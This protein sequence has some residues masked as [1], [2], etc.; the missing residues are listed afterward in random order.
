MAHARKLDAYR[1]KRDFA[2][3]AEPRGARAAGRSPRLRFVI[4]KHA[5]RRLHYDLRLELDGVFKSWAVTR[6]P[7]LDPADKR[8]AIEVEDH[9]LEYGD[10]EGT[11]PKGEYGGGTVQIWDRGYWL[12]EEGESPERALEA[13][14]L[15]FTLVGERL[16]GRF[17]LVRMR[18]PRGAAR[19]GGREAGRTADREAARAGGREAGRRNWLLIKRRDEWASGVGKA[20]EA[21]G[22]MPSFVPP[23]LCRLVD[24]PP[25]GGGWA[26][27]VKFDGY[28]LQLRVS[29]GS[30]RLRT[31]KGLDWTDKF[32]TI[33]AEARE[34]PDCIIDGE[35]V[36]L[37][38]HGVPS[39]AALQAA[40]AARDT[41]NAVFF[42][43]DLL[44][45]QGADLRRLPLRD[46]K[47]RL[48]A[49]LAP[50]EDAGHI[51]YVE[52][53]ESGADALL[54][55]AC[56][57][58]LEG[59]VSKRL[60]APYTS[61]RGDAWAKAKCRGGQ[62]VVIGAWTGERGAFRSLLAGVFSAG[63]LIYVG[64]VGTGYGSEVARTLL[65]RLKPLASDINPFSGEPPLT[66]KSDVHWVRPEL[67]AEIELSGWTGSGMIRQAAFKGLREDKPAREVTTE[68]PAAAK[69][70]RGRRAVPAASGADDAQGARS[71]AEGSPIVMGV[72]ISNPEKPL[73][74]SANDG[75]PVTKLEL[76][77]YY[78]SV[79]P[80][81]IGH[82][83]G[84]PCSL[85]RAP[86]G[87][88][89][90]HFFQRHAMPGT[91][92]LLETTKVSGDRKPYLMIDRIE[93]LAAVAQIAGVELHP[94][95]SE[96]GRPDRPGR[97]VFDIDPAPDVPFDR[98]VAAALELRER[99]EALGLECFCKTTGGKGLHVVTPLAASGRIDWPT[100]KTFAQAV[101]AQMAADHPERYLVT[102]SKKARAG[103]LYLDYLR[104]DRFATAVAPLSPRAREGA[105]VSMP[106]GWEQ[107][108]SGLAPGR[109]TV[110]TAPGLLAKAKP[111]GGYEDAARPLERAIQRLTGSGA[112]GT[113]AH[114]AEARSTRAAR[115]RAPGVRVGRKG[116]ADTESG[117]PRGET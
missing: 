97:L 70:R 49:L 21:P 58:Q 22:P 76:A 79:G 31:R 113:D 30:A 3:T 89:G 81:M 115:V 92:S 84:R 110:R 83:R 72:R 23:Q 109:F 42:A 75:R 43:F 62:E 87:I 67:V 96:P 117:R 74:P 11:I 50:H 86:D 51:R 17:V 106:L 33:A 45:A 14:E 61:G 101:C 63:R 56:R 82:L 59:I 28:R 12:P 91:S 73:W 47:R 48:E 112:R 102:M 66:R 69:Q 46:R 35:A 57:M 111:W 90:Q 9:P 26:H 13:G 93:A 99:L 54:K 77:Q 95:N 100:A 5:A 114:S 85:V 32:A 88:G 24:R 39:F 10:F 53:F 8:L 104:N 15:K 29:G 40:L 20:P 52:H 80:W 108:R 107:V 25:G 44:Y 37:D 18:N 55:S 116:R 64:R 60:D 2:K 7:S 71:G 105:P 68:L 27:E 36:A 19:A 103:R 78:A 38:R 1:A 6:C 4:Q 94:W 65:A 16:N 34:L 41:R 98:V